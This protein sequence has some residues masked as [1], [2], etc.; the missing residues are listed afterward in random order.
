MFYK[1]LFTTSRTRKQLVKRV[2]SLLLP[3]MVRLRTY[4]PLTTAPGGRSFYSTPRKR[5]RK[6]GA[7]LTSALKGVLAKQREERQQRYTSALQDARNTVQ[8]H[9]T[10]LREE[11]GG[12]S[13]G[14]YHQEILQRGRLERG[15]RKSSRWNA[16]LRHELKKRNDGTSCYL[17]HDFQANAG[18]QELPSGAPKLKSHDVA[19]EVSATWNS[20]CHETKVMATDGL[21]E[22]LAE[23]RQEADTRAKVMPVHI[24]NDVSATMAKIIR[25]VCPTYPS[26]H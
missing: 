11:F 1:R 3:T 24:L 9:A 4:G 16:F 21:L 5:A 6:R 26:T 7:P 13:I 23:T 12:H 25:E 18:N 2:R 14:Y 10:R 15:R 8:Q 20:M 19:T 17:L 22:E